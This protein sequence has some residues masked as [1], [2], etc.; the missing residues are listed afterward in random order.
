ME[1][2]LTLLGYAALAALVAVSL[3]GF[4]AAVAYAVVLFAGK[5]S[6]GSTESRPLR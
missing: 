5:H 3:G 2:I 4:A 6:S 1:L